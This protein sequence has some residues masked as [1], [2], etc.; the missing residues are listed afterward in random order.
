L[1]GVAR[2]LRLGPQVVGRESLGALTLYH[3]LV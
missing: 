2:L 3:N 1:D